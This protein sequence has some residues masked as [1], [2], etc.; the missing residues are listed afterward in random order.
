[1]SLLFDLFVFLFFGN[2][3]IQLKR[4][5]SYYHLDDKEMKLLYAERRLGLNSSK[6]IFSRFN[7]T[8]H[9]PHFA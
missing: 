4:D 3:T 9:Q 7:M 6:L 8:V 5:L 1:M 2:I